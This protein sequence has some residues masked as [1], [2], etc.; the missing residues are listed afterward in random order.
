[1]IAFLLRFGDRF[2]RDHERFRRVF[3]SL[4]DQPLAEPLLERLRRVVGGV[5]LVLPSRSVV[6]SFLGER[7][8]ELFRYGSGDLDRVRERDFL[9]RLDDERLRDFDLE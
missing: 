6:T 7:E 9:D 4:D 2:S 1:M 3:S 5:F 8:R